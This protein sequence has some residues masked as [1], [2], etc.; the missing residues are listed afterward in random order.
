MQFPQRHDW[1]VSPKEAIAIQQEL[2]DGVV[3][4]DELGEV[5]RVA[6]VDVAFPEKGQVTQAGVVVLD[7]PSLQVVEQA[8]ARVATTLPY[9]PGL[10]SFREIP[11]IL[12]ALE[13]LKTL[14]DLILCDGQGLAHPRRFGLACHLGVLT[15][16]ATIGVGKTRFVGK[17]EPVGEE[18]GAY[19][20]LW[21]K[22]EIVGVVL[23]S[24]TKVKP[25]YV[26]IGHR[27]SLETAIEYVLACTPKYR[28]PETTRLADRLAA[29]R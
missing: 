16:L 23:R 26:S 20:W 9:V 27:V 12:Q 6:G 8:V 11:A 3:R 21:D 28:L 1:N 14:P 4:V 19:K 25:I 2:R 22:G 15:G 24:R 17:H 7:F 18:K 10:L 29:G 5:K 13:Q